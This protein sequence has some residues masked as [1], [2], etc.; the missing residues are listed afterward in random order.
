[1]T[2][3]AYDGGDASEKTKFLPDLGEIAYSVSGRRVKTKDLASIGKLVSQAYREKYGHTTPHKTQR[4]CNG[5]NVS[6]NAYLCEDREL[7]HDAVRSFFE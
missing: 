6:V 4:Y 5:A 1:M 2:L 7:V 3:I